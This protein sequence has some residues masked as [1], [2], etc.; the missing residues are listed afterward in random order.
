VQVWDAQANKSI[1]K[2][3]NLF[4]WD[5]HAGIVGTFI[6]LKSVHDEVNGDLNQK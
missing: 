5:W 4:S 6:N 3:E 1:D 2:I